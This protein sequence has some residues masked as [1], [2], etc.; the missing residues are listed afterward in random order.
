VLTAPKAESLLN[1]LIMFTAPKAATLLN[2]LN[3]LTVLKVA[4]LFGSWFR[5]KY[6]NMYK[7]IQQD[8]TVSWLLFQELH[9]ELRFGGLVVSMLASGAQVC[10]F[11]N[12]EKFLSMPSFG[13]EVNPSVPCRRFSA[14]KISLNG[15]E[16]ASFRQKLPDTILA[17]I[18]TIRY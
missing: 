6:F 4:S 18:S 12:G 13:G 14:C 11:K 3:T 1:I 7:Y 15:V 9:Q 2:A 8:A 10:G 17:H 5:A 16:N